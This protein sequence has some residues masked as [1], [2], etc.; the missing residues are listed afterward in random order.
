[1]PRVDRRTVLIFNPLPHALRHYASALRSNLESAGFDCRRVEVDFELAGR[2]RFQRAATLFRGLMTF[3][4]F[5]LST[6]TVVVIWPTFGFLD[7][8]LWQ[9]YWRGRRYVVVHDPVPLRRQIGYS[10]IAARL[11][12][13]ANASSRVQL[14]AH[15]RMAAESLAA[16]GLRV[17]HILPHPAFAPQRHFS[18]VHNGTPIILVAGQYK[19]ARDVQLLERIATE[20]PAHWQ[21]RI[22]GRG[23]PDVSG[24]QVD[25]RFLS[26]EEMNATI[27]SA[28]AVL[29]PYAY[30]F[31]SGIAVRAFEAGVPV[32]ARRHE[33]IESLYGARWPG[34]VDGEET[35]TWLA[36]LAHI[37]NQLVSF[38][39][40]TV[41]QIASAWRA[42][43]TEDG[44]AI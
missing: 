5:T 44:E 22:V 2:T 3:A 36:T 29:I 40:V 38:E 25:S 35:A 21:L 41:E 37:F 30:Y 9:L 16:Q 23:W 10:R 8:L 28:S 13:L 4:K 34:M 26:E 32:V 19:Q 15:T 43:L 6:R 33:F 7:L 20:A 42:S 17:S 14:V 39:S 27:H 12:A 31:Q 1:M 24:W 18:E 11:G